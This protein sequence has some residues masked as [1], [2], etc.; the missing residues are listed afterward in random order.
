MPGFVINRPVFIGSV[1]ITGMFV[2]IGAFLP[3]RAETIFGAV[4]GWTLASFGW[5]FL[6]AVAIFLGAVVFD[7]AGWAGAMA[8]VILAAVTAATIATFGAPR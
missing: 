8:M 5:L 3:A 2:A 4:Q 1:A 7:A 6:L